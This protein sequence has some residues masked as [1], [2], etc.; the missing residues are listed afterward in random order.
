MRAGQQT[1][2]ALGTRFSLDFQGSRP[3]FDAAHAVLSVLNALLAATHSSVT[4]PP[5]GC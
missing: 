2:Y 4:I 3:M 1:A 5:I